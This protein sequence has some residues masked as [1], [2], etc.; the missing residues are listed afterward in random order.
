[1]TLRREKNPKKLGNANTKNEVKPGGTLKE[2]VF[3][4]RVGD[5]I[6]CVMFIYTLKDAQDILADN[7]SNLS[8]FDLVCPCHPERLHFFMSSVMMTSNL[9]PNG[10]PRTPRNPR[11]MKERARCC[12][13][14][15]S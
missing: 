1:M 7:G 10:H 14:M 13:V 9:D 3:L 4:G 8:W 5:T 2:F 12:W 6:S 11:N 15:H